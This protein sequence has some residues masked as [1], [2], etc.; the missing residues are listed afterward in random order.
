MPGP[1]W[2]VLRKQY[3]GRSFRFSLPDPAAGAAERLFEVARRYSQCLR[4]AAGFLSG[5][6]QPSGLNALA[7][8]AGNGRPDR[9]IRLCEPGGPAKAPYGDD[10]VHGQQDADFLFD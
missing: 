6:I 9:Q 8:F 10:P 7:G 3:R 5:G 1:G 2:I 4:E